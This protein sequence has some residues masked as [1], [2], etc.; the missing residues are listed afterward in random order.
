MS[1]AWA[2][3]LPTRRRDGAMFGVIIVGTGLGHA[4]LKVDKR[5][6]DRDAGLREVPRVALAEHFT[7]KNP[8]KRSDARKL[9]GGVVKCFPSSN[10]TTGVPRKQ[11]FSSRRPD[12][13]RGPL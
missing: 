10:E 13:N 1:S 9:V 11:A 2:S 3:L 7:C 12:S 5:C 8:C 6:R 4:A